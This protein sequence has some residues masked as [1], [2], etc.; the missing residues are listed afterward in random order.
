[1]TQEFVSK[2]FFHGF[3]NTEINIGEYYDILYNMSRN[4]FNG[5]I[6]QQFEIIDIRKS[7]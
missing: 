3:F 4:Y 5:N 7:I 2:G 6:T 1:M